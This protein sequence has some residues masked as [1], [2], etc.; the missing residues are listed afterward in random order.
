[1]TC[2]SSL[3]KAFGGEG[4]IVFEPIKFISAKK[5]HHTTK[6]DYYALSSRFSLSSLLVQPIFQTTKSYYIS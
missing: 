6:V 2:T 5:S 3:V 1:M 4:L